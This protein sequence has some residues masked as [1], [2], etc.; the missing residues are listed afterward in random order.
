[1]LILAAGL[2]MPASAQ[3]GGGEG[4]PNAPWPRYFAYSGV[5]QF[6][7]GGSAECAAMSAGS[8]HMVVV[9]RNDGPGRG[10][11]AYLVGEQIMHGMIGGADLNRLSVRYL[12]ESMPTHAMQLRFTGPGQVIGAVPSKTVVSELYAACGFSNAQFKL[13]I[14]PGA[15]AQSLFALYGAQFDLDTQAMKDLVAARQG[16][17]REALPSLQQA[18]ALKS[19]TFA[20]THPQMLR[21]YFYLAQGYEEAGAYPGA[22]YWYGKSV[23]ACQQFG[24]D[25]ACAA[26]TNLNLGLA[27]ANNGSTNE[28]EPAVRQALDIAGR[29][30]G[31]DAPAA[32]VGYNALGRILIENGRFGEAEAQLKRAGAL[33]RKEFAIEQ[34]APAVA[35]SFAMLHRQLG[36]LDKAESDLRA[37][38][39]QI[40]S[41][42][43]PG[44]P[45]SVAPRVFLAKILRLAGKISEAES[46]AR[47]A[48]DD[49]VRMA[50]PERPDHPLLSP[51]RIA[52]ADVL[53]D[54]KRFAEAEPLYREALANSSRFLGPHH[55]DVAIEQLQYARMLRALGRDQEAQELLQKA[56]ATAHVSDN[57]IVAW[58]VPG[59]LMQLYAAGPLANRPLAIFYGKEAVNRLQSL[60]GNLAGSGGANQSAFVSAADVSS[61]YQSLE[62]LLIEDGRLDETQQVFTAV[63]EQELNQFTGRSTESAAPSA[64]ARP[65][66]LVDLNPAEKQLQDD[67]AQMVALGRELGALQDKYDIEGDQMSSADKARLEQLHQKVDAA[68]KAADAR[69]AAVARNSASAGEAKLR[70][71]DIKNFSRAFQGT[72]HELGHDAVVVQYHISPGKVTIFLTTA[73]VTVT[74]ESAI[75]RADLD[76]RI[77]SFRRTLSGPQ[78]DPLPEAQALYRVL[79]APIADDLRQAGAKTLMLSLED[80]LRYLPFAALHDGKSYLI[81]DYAIAMVTEAARDK[82]T[83]APQPADWGVWGLGVTKGGRDYPPLPAVQDELTGIAAQLGGRSKVSLDQD[84]TERTLRNG[85]DQHYPIIHIASHFLFTPGSMDDSILLLGDGKTLSLA[86][87]RDKLQFDRVE[88][89]TLSACQTAV[90]DSGAPRHGV[91]VESLGAI[92]QQAGAKAVLASLWSVSDESTAALMRTLYK[93]EKEDHVTKAEALRRSQLALL[94]GTAAPAATGAQRG[95]SRVGES[96]GAA[97]VAPGSGAPYAHPFYWAPF[98]LMG[99]WL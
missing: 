20:P 74:R 59:E 64:P 84:F 60:R 1:M 79:V 46:T 45:A 76:Q 86:A 3:Y 8:Y 68:Q 52:L 34:D 30:F 13:Q 5:L 54:E 25:S 29:A 58:R 88:L 7:P 92:A 6:L 57:Q 51:A 98:V 14:D 56:Y 19:K 50:G 63:K 89:L 12:G 55:P 72:L 17:V 48:L 71:Q 70:A 81:E 33:S 26:I 75:K 9:G 36:Q 21:Y 97:G 80:T 85:L 95:L 44:K 40:D 67:D 77:F 47:G 66:T 61:I 38:L 4:V 82:L 22:V 31:P 37:A 91:E 24:P 87:I 16:R 18:I 83:Q 49:A 69:A 65:A 10:I 28:A 11:Q 23:A 27:L 94:H 32:W 78:Q 73:N 99:N 35:V 39:R 42:L 96:Q 53:A 15:D 93:E 90:G 2:A 43:G 41:A 62:D